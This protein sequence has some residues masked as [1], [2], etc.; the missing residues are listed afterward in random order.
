AFSEV[1]VVVW[2]PP[3]RDARMG[4]RRPAATCLKSLIRTSGSTFR[5]IMPYAPLATAKIDCNS[6][7]E[8]RRTIRLRDASA[9][10]DAKT[11]IPDA[12]GIELSSSAISGD[13][14]R[15]A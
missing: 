7:S 8:A 13:R 1:S 10:A 4:N 6:V 14:S 3:D 5:G 9:I 2:A 12:L 11:L 15:I